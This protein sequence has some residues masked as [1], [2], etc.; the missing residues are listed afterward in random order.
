EAVERFHH[1]GVRV[2][3]DGVVEAHPRQQPAEL[4][5]VLDQPGP[6]DDQQRGAV[7]REQ[8]VDAARQVPL[9]GGGRGGGGVGAEGQGRVVDAERGG[10]RRRTE[11]GGAGGDR[12]RGGAGDAGGGHRVQF[13]RRTPFTANATRQSL[14]IGAG[15]RGR[16]VP[17][18]LTTA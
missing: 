2:G 18:A 9:H 8:L 6:V 17:A 5:V 15:R 13:H 3:L 7:Q 14:R 12:S 1:I 10:G 11:S 4:Q 16:P